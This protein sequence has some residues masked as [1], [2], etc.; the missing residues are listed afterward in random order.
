MK[1]VLVVFGGRSAEHDISIITAHTPIMAALAAAGTYE[2]VPLYISKQGQWYS[3]SSLARIETYQ[4][5][6]FEAK[7]TKLRPVDLRIGGGLKL[8]LP[9]LRPKEVAIDVVFT[10]MHGTYGE[11]G[12]L[13][14]LLRMA[15][16]PFVGCDQAA[17]VIAMDKVLTKV[18]TEAL[19]I[20]SVNYTWFWRK[21]WQDDAPSVRQRLGKLKLPLFVKPAHLGSSI[22]IT[23]VRQ[24]K[25]LEGALEVAMHYDDKV[26]VEE[27]VEDLIEVTLPIMG[28][29]QPQPALLE[30]PLNKTEFFDFEE[31]YIGQGKKTAGGANQSY[32]E[33]PAKLPKQLYARAVQVGI[34]TYRAVGCAGIARVDML[35]DS[36][37]KQVYLNEINPLPGSLYHHNWREAGVSATELVSRLIQLA[38][39][40]ADQDQKTTFTFQSSVLQQRPGN[41]GL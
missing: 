25:D 22:G 28:N 34:E 15:G 26:I 6:E 33:L 27:S 11:D 37:T 8:V 41:K 29:D 35:I 7:L 1:R 12:S 5:P 32:S 24:A 4:D 2:I 39:E 19:G 40:R 13:M 18:T 3:H 31:K 14:G 38:E 16:V 21:E 36:K 23:K 10:A 9:G 30:R 20:P 17:S